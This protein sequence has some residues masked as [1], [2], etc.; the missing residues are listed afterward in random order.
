MEIAPFVRIP[1]L[2]QAQPFVD[3]QGRLTSEALRTLNGALTQLAEAVNQL[4]ALPEIEAA[5]EAAQAAVIE[6][7]QAANDA[8]GA[9]EANKRETAIQTSYID[10]MSVLS[11]SPSLITVAS[12]TRYYPQPTGAPIGVSVNGGNVVATGPDDVNYVFYIDPERDGGSVTYQVSTDPPTQ[13][14]DTHVVGAVTI[15]AAGT[16]DGGDGPT[17]PGYVRPNELTPIP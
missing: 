11:A 5:L 16:V 4:A 10:P 1:T 13:T 12:H 14:G 17:R 7:Q 8:K 6:A 15:P 9:S 3:S 2:T